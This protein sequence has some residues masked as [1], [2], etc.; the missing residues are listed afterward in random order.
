MEEVRQIAS[1]AMTYLQQHYNY[2]REGH[3]AFPYFFL[4]NRRQK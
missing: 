2:L 3:C 1:I 4:K